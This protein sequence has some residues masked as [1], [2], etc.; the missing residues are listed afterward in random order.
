MVKE[1]MRVISERMLINGERYNPHLFSQPNHN[2]LLHLAMSLTM[3]LNIDRNT[4]FC[5]KA[6]IVAASKSHGVPQPTKIISNDERR[7]VLGTFYLTSNVFSSFRK[8]DVLHWSPWLT[9]CADALSREPE[10]DSDVLLGQLVQSQRIMQEALCTQYDHAPSQFFAKS[11]LSDLDRIGSQPG[12]GRT[13][14]ILR[15]QQACTRAAIWERSFADLHHNKANPSDLRQRLEGIWRCME[16]VK[17]YIGLYMGVPV[18]DYPIVSFGVFAQF[19]FIFVVVIRASSLNVDGWDVHAVREYVDFSTLMEE[20]ARRYDAVTHA[21]PDGLLLKNEGF[22]KW[23]AKTKWA[24]AFYETKFMAAALDE[25]VERNKMTGDGGNAV[26]RGTSQILP[27]LA[28]PV[29]LTTRMDVPAQTWP[30]VFPFCEE[31][32]WNGWNDP[33]QLAE[34]GFEVL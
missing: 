24:K 11:F 10:Y 3:D 18:E 1:L 17:A 29:H 25:Q 9:E 8:V 28:S 26:D 13:A 6:T 31:T 34:L 15:L 27:P 14:T 2:S 32:F 19:A 22:A 33:M 30:D 21:R 12:E 20:A 23:A 4:G 16:A 5:E 7:A